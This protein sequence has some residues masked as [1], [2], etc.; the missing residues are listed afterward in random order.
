MRD[1]TVK[2]YEKWLGPWVTWL[3]AKAHD[4]QLVINKH[5]LKSHLDQRFKGGQSSS[6]MRVGN[7]IADFV[8]RYLPDRIEVIDPGELRRKTENVQMPQLLLDKLIELCL[9][10]GFEESKQQ[11]DALSTQQHSKFLGKYQVFKAFLL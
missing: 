11:Q 7:Q 6:Y 8:S 1:D 9:A 10:K 5:V 3:E 4:G 2:N